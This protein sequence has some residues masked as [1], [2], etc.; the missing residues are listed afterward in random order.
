MKTK[1][2]VIN[3]CYGGFG[4]SNEALLELINMKSKIVKKMSI[5]K[6]Y[7]GEN[8]NFKDTWK[9]EWNKDKINLKPFK[10]GFFEHPYY[11]GILYHN[12]F[13]YFIE[14]CSEIRSNEDLIKVVEK[15]KE[16][17]SGKLSELIIV[18]IPEDVDY[19]IDDYDG[20]ETIH[21]EHRSWG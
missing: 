12:E 1:K 10:E 5:I 13:V 17:A 20:M 21:E 4:I 9:E 6:Y 7:G 15:L 14:D 2:I 11:K 3:R 8:P 16:K 18:E 19:E